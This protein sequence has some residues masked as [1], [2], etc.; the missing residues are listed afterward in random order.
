[1]AAKNPAPGLTD[2]AVND[3]ASTN[4]DTAININVLANDGANGQ[5]RTV[6]SLAPADATVITTATTA[7]GATVTINSDGSVHYD[8]SSAPGIQALAQGETEP[9]SFIYTL[10]TTTPSGAQ[11]HLSQATVTVNLTGVNDPPVIHD[12][13]P[14]EPQA[15]TDT[16]PINPFSAVSVSDADHNAQDSATITLSNNANGTL[17][18]TGLSATGTPGV[19][20]ITATSPGTLTSDLQSISFNPAAPPVNGS[21]TTNF[22]LSVSDGIAPPVSDNNISVVD[23]ATH[24]PVDHVYQPTLQSPAQ[25]LFSDAKGMLIDASNTGIL[26]FDASNI[27][28]TIA[29]HPITS[30]TLDL[31]QIAFARPPG[32]SSPFTVNIETF[33]GTGDVTTDLSQVG[34]LVGTAQVSLSLGFDSVTLNT[35]ALNQVLG[36][37]GDLGFALVAQSPNGSQSLL[38]EGDF[39][40]G[41]HLH[42]TA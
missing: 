30:A 4:E 23:T 10:K 29:S 28:S 32:G 33:N 6:Y 22:S 9:D 19:Y 14:T 25:H 24:T 37:G 16:N 20:T 21:T 35:S 26:E 41:F 27:S 7:R 42:L 40:G 5:T 17:S 38:D 12:A 18:G 1:M 3:T 15:T 8:P 34:A 39:F 31:Q 11:S 36:Q 2:Q 13:T